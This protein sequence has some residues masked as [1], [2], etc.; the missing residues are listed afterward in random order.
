MTSPHDRPDA[1]E[2][3]E[4]VRA[5]LAEEVLDTVEGKLRF[6]VRVA[7]NA[8]SIAERELHHGSEHRRE[9]LSNLAE[10]GC[11]D[12]DELAEAIRTGRLD[13]RWDEV[14]AA[15]RSA[16]WAKI[17]VVNPKYVGEDRPPSLSA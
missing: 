4:A 3:V 10:L 11:R 17:S 6:R 5:L 2:L 14:V 12:D 9:H 7:I 13:D 16:V 1:V 15:V 8:L